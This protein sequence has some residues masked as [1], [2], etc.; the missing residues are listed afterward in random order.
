MTSVPKQI[1]VI[2]LSAFQMKTT[3]IRGN[4]YT[5]LSIRFFTYIISFK[6]Q[7]KPWEKILSFSLSHEKLR[8]D[9]LPKANG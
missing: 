6:S 2:R 7:S 1:K 3:I 9:D 5:Q 4:I 8:V